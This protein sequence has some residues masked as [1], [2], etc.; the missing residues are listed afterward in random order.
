[1]EFGIYK[2]ISQM[3]SL[4]SQQLISIK[5]LQND[6]RFLYTVITNALKINSN[7]I[8]CLLPYLGLI[9]DGAEDWIKAFNNS[10]KNGF[11]VP[12]YS[13]DEQDFYEKMR[14]SVKFWNEPYESIYHR[15]E[16]RYYESDLYFSSLC[17]PIAK[18]LKLYDIYGV[19]I[20]QG[21]YCG[22]TIL[23]SLFTP[24]YEFGRE[25][26]DEIKRLSGFAG[27]Y[28]AF[29]NALQ[30]YSL[31]D[32]DFYTV[33]YGGFRKSP[34][35]N[36][37]SDR[38]VLFS[39]LC[40]VNFVLICILDFVADE[41]TTKLRFAYI[42]Y[43]YVVNVLPEINNK[44]NACFM[45]DDAWHNKYFRNC[46]AHY[47]VGIVLKHSDIVLDDPFFGLVQKHFNLSY[48]DMKQKIVSELISI[49]GQLERFLDIPEF[50]SI[51]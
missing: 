31:N 2:D 29:F 17:K 19:D 24:N 23:C 47:K 34:F 49:S 18:T 15:L 3:N 33:D 41:T 30:P 28:T 35:G 43:Y 26:G 6:F 16:Q 45:V 39:L 22:N 8:T 51:T 1:M 32:M 50:L 12:S 5:L 9:V 36:K 42:L 37:F 7:Y 25:S 38:F 48:N 21:K 44:L 13:P 20:V 11:H 14:N 4:T 46:M 27:H 40:Q 10:H